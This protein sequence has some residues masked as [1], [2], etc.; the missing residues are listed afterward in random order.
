MKT[1][2]VTSI[3]RPPGAFPP[4][5]AAARTQSGRYRRNAPS[6]S[7]RRRVFSAKP[8]KTSDGGA[9]GVSGRLRD[10][11]QQFDIPTSG[12]GSINVGSVAQAETRTLPAEGAG[13]AP[14]RDSLAVNKQID[15]AL[16][17][18]YK[19]NALLNRI[20]KKQVRCSLV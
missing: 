13:E 12:E 2:E 8:V 6:D 20:A 18:D 15:N 17:Q 3:R 10:F 19:T 5:V 14:K 7:S 11:L 16:R 4:S 1:A 9:H